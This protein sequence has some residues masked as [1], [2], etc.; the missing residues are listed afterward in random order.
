MF[1]RWKKK[2]E[3]K[4]G[5]LEERQYIDGKVVSKNIAYLGTVEKAKGKLL[6]LLNNGTITQIEFEKFSQGLPD[7]KPQEPKKKTMEVDEKEYTTM[8]TIIQNQAK[9]IQLLKSQIGNF[10]FEKKLIRKKTLEE[11]RKERLKL[12]EKIRSLEQFISDL[13]KE[14]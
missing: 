7:P 3:K 11:S 8:Q 4:Y 13:Q 9:E 5:Y 10:E 2:N 14:G 1:L 6:D 12:K